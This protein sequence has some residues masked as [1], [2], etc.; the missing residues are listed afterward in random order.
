M[1]LEAFVQLLALAICSFLAALAA[2]WVMSRRQ[3]YLSKTQSAK[4]EVLDDDVVFLF[5]DDVLVNGTDGAHHL[6]S[7]APPAETDWLKFIAATNGRFP[8]FQ[9]TVLNLADNTNFST[10][11]IDGVSKLSA[12]S[13]GETLRIS[14]EDL[15]EGD[16]SIMLE[17]ARQLAAEKEL[18][19]L[20]ATA[21]YAPFLVWR[22]DGKGS[23]TWANSSYLALSQNAE[24][25]TLTAS[26]PPT[27]LFDLSSTPDGGAENP[28]QRLTTH[29]PGEAEPRWFE[30]FETRI[31]DESIFTAVAA[32]K[33]V[34]AE[35]ALRDFVQTLTKTFAHLT[36]GLAIFD[37]QRRL[38]LFNPAL[39][40][41]TTLSAS[42]LSGRPTF[43]DVV[44]QL[45]EKQMIPEPKDYKSWRRRLNELEVAAV[46]GTY[47]ETWALAN[48]QT[49][50]VT[51]RPHPDGAVAFL[52]EDISAEISL[53]RRFRAELRNGQAVLDTL[54]Q[55]MAVFSSTGDLTLS[56]A[57]YSQL[58]GIDPTTI[59]GEFGIVD[60]TRTWAERCAPTPVWGDVREFV[61]KMGERVEWS[62]DVQ[63]RD[64]RW[65]TCQ[66]T[67][68]S[69]GAMLVRFTAQQDRTIGFPIEPG[70]LD[71]SEIEAASV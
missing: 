61:S 7:S 41:L 55:G 37:K 31:G 45:R 2:L 64:G 57:A 49:F 29:I 56:N 13:F 40:D 48:G 20:R 60:A 53:T 17:R 68:I 10:F 51:G 69:G 23:I 12:H 21:E 50:R 52:F 22:Q 32:D 43:R 70:T 25:D 71:S 67:P 1:G 3:Y 14:I 16:A 24:N 62:A 30:C 5:E 35:V 4:L 26:W 36:I 28:S 65:L 6:M 33:V 27:K 39:T 18:E 59:I 58:W 9:K 34:K 11:S 8:V 42:F 19:T 47:E 38:A 66:F 15:S 44:D 46:N 63:L 54:D